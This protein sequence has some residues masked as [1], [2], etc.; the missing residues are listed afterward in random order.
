MIRQGVVFL[1]GA[2]LLSGCAHTQNAA[3]NMPDSTEGEKLAQRNNAASLLND[4]LNDEKNVNKLLLIKHNSKEL[5]HLIDA[6]SLSSGDAQ[7]Q[8]E[9]LA[10][11]DPQ[12]NL[13]ALELPAGEKATRD[14]IAKTKE[15]ELLFSSGEN[16][17]F[18]LLL[19][20]ADALSYG[21]HLAGICAKDSSRPEEVRAFTG[22][23][24][25]ME[26]LYQQVVTMMKTEPP[27]TTH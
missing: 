5:G 7:K 16:F 2:A 3:V 24:L 13:H 6:V 10:K 4:L 22:I 1:L 15:H 26:D 23:R 17:Q 27:A 20:Q 25:A 21:W 11:A 12:M 18:Q 9:A 14:A 8:L 19:T